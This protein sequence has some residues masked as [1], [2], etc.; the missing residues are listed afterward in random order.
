MNTLF[1]SSF[2]F[3]SD[4]IYTNTHDSL[5]IIRIYYAPYASS[6][7]N[8]TY[9]NQSNQKHFVLT[10]CV[11]IGFKMKMAQLMTPDHFHFSI[12]LGSG[13][14]SNKKSDAVI[15]RAVKMLGHFWNHVL[16]PIH[17]YFSNGYN[18]KKTNTSWDSNH[19]LSYSQSNTHKYTTKCFILS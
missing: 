14:Y 12:L 7:H 6:H 8:N 16:G 11:S 15:E 4:I 17:I 18:K 9:T 3:S 10:F 1:R 13:Y 19:S 2:S 5:M